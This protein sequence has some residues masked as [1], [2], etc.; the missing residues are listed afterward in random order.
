MPERC[1]SVHPEMVGAIC[2]RSVCLIS[3][4]DHQPPDRWPSGYWRWSSKSRV[5]VRLLHIQRL[6]VRALGVSVQIPN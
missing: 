6:Q 3:N 4:E 2:I 5:V 1:H